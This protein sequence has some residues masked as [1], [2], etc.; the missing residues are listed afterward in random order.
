MEWKDEDFA[1]PIVAVACPSSA[2]YSPCNAH[3]DVL[4]ELICKEI[5]R[6]G[7]KPILFS[8]PT[9]NDGVTMGTDG[10]RYSL[11][12]RDLIADCVETMYEGYL[13]DAIVTGS[14]STYLVAFES[15]SLLFSF[16]IFFLHLF[17]CVL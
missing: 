8:T 16:S 14:L 7:G 12:S 9:I 5:V 10:M 4:G 1:K 15:R 13:C 17:L 6:L 2:T 11:P 3:F